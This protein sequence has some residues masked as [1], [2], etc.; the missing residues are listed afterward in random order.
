MTVRRAFGLDSAAMARLGGIFNSR[1]R[2]FFDMFEE[3]ARNVVRGADLLDQ[4]LAHFPDRADLAR[5]IV[6]CEQEG[7]RIT[8]DIHHRLNS[9]F[10]TPIDREDIL[11]LTS[12][13]DDIIDLIDEVADYLGLYKIEAPMEQSQR[14]AHILLQATRQI[15]SAM[16]RLRSFQDMSHFTVEVNR[17]EN[18]G[19]RM[20]RNAIASLFDNGIDPMVV[21]RW[22][23]IFE[24]LEEAIDACE[25]VANTLEGIVIKNS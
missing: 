11:E 10:V 2:E 23:D 24:R 4:M 15:E 8:H 9:T 19:D 5:D 16:P 3:A 14:M 1:D 21:I 18:D 12:D 17:L 20:S 22:K 6:I 7:D 13:M 25:H